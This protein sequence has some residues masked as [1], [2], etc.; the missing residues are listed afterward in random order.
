MRL[1]EHYDRLY[2]DSLKKLLLNDYQIDTLIDSSSDKRYGLTLLL[3][4]DNN[5]K[6]KIQKFLNEL[7]I[8]EPGQY[9]YP[10]SDIHVTIMSI[11]SCYNG[12]QLAKI[13]VEEYRKVIQK[14]I[15]G[16]SRFEIEFK[17]ITASSSCIM[18]QGFYKD[19]TLNQIRNNLR[20]N[21]SESVL[22]QSIDKRYA[23]HTAHSTVFRLK[24]SYRN[25]ESFIRKIE[26][27]RDYD[28]GTFIVN[29]LE[30]VFN[31]WDQREKNVKTLCRFEL[32]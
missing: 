31:D 28:F 11:I 5:V 6:N 12:F 24:E 13:P 17:G 19:D 25:K 10:D 16:L 26:E 7:K 2:H 14:S 27:Y 4:P 29:N 9:F 8:I 22:E 32:N 3:R 18:V 20:I 15:N 30:L 1:I 21:F 23:I